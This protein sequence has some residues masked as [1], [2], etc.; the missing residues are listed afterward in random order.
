MRARDGFPPP[1]PRRK[2]ARAWSRSRN[3]LLDRHGKSAPGFWISR[4]GA[5]IRPPPVRR[6]RVCTLDTATR[7][8]HARLFSDRDVRIWGRTVALKRPT[9]GVVHSPNPGRVVRPGLAMYPLRRAGHTR[10]P[11]YRGVRRRALPP[12][13]RGIRPLRPER[14]RGRHGRRRH[15]AAAPTDVRHTVPFH[16]TTS[17]L[18]ARAPT[19]D[20]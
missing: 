11:R 8:G 9:W 2:H 7:P 18:V 12:R 14:S 19:P 13:R 5:S 4:F 20:G 15:A 17:T 3:S 6:H 1:C 16:T 10:A